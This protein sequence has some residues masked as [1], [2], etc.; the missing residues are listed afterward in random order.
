LKALLLWK[1][2][3]SM[4]AL[5]TG[6]GRV[7]RRGGVQHRHDRL[8]GGPHRPVY[9][10][11]SSHDLSLMGNYGSIPRILNP[12][13]IH[14]EGLASGGP[15]HLPTGAPKGTWRITSRPPANWVEGLDTGLYETPPGSGAMRGIISTSGSGP[16]LSGAPG[17]ELPSMEGLDWCPMVTVTVPIG[18]P[19]PGEGTGPGDLADL[20]GPKDAAQGHPLRLWCKV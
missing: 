12:G 7:F 8:S 9:K 13:E 6:A 14:V 2:V 11:R 1:M 19:S 4:G 18:G 20:V 5:F 16:P 10:G 17:R 3:W 15:P